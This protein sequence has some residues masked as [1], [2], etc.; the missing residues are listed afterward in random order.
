MS[1]P[2]ARFVAGVAIGI[3]LGALLSALVAFSVGR[4]APGRFQIIN[5]SYML[6]T[7]RGDVYRQI[8]VDNSYYW[9]RFVNKAK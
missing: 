2:S 1:G 8:T 9:S 4:D 7:G 5:G 6:D 3:S